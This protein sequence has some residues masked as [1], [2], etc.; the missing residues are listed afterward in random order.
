MKVKNNTPEVAELLQ[1][2]DFIFYE[3]LL[4]IDFKELKKGEKKTVQLQISEIPEGDKVEYSAVSCGCTQP[5]IF[6]IDGTTQLIEVNFKPNSK[7]YFTKQITLYNKD[8]TKKQLI[9]LTGNAV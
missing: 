5:K 4:T 1:K 3:D 7:G 9:K 6:G 2:Q 8:K